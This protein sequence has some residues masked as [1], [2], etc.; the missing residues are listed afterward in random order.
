[1]VEDRKMRSCEW[2]KL[3][4]EG[5]LGLDVQVVELQEA[6]SGRDYLGKGGVYSSS[7]FSASMENRLRFSPATGLISSF[8]TGALAD[9]P[10]RATG[11]T[12]VTA[13]EFLIPGAK[14]DAVSGLAIFGVFCNPRISTILGLLVQ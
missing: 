1:M 4:V 6:L 14:A 7:S 13:F 3:E 8:F 12:V 10:S 2:R 9:D 5:K 11:A